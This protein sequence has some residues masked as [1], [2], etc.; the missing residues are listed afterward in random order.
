[1]PKPAPW[2]AH[3]LAYAPNP[4][5]PSPSNLYKQRSSRD[6]NFARSK[7]VQLAGQPDWFSR[8]SVSQRPA[9]TKA[10]T[11]SGIS[12]D[13]GTAHQLNRWQ[14][15]AASRAQSAA[16]LGW[17]AQIRVARSGATPAAIRA[18]ATERKEEPLSPGPSSTTRN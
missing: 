17:C 3:A 1:G 18:S 6:R 16:G 7:L 8:S 5:G 13:G 2:S 10:P 14:R 11:S 4:Y 9:P 15:A 12:V